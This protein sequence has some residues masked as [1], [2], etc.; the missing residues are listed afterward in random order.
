MQNTIYSFTLAA[1]VKN[2]AKP[3]IFRVVSFAKRRT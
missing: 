2:G 1:I 3:C